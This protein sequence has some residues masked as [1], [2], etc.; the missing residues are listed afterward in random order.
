M[1]TDV[2]TLPLEGIIGFNGT[3]PNGLKV[4]SDRQHLVYPLGCNVVIEDITK[5][6][7][8]VP[9]ILSE[10]TDDVTCL[11]ISNLDG[12]YIASG[13]TTHMGFKATI[14]IWDYET[15][16]PIHKMALHKVKVEALAFTKNDRYLIS[17]GGQDDGSVVIWDVET[18]E[19]LCGSPAQHKSAG[20]TYCLN[21]SNVS[22]KIFVTGGDNTLRVWEIDSANRKIRP[23]DVNMGGVKRIIHCIQVVDEFSPAFIFC[24][25][26][27]GDILAIN[28]DSYRLT[29][30]VPEKEKFCQGITALAFVR[31]DNAIK[32]KEGN[33][34]TLPLYEFVIGAGDGTLGQYNIKVTIVGNKIKSSFSHKAC[35]K[36]WKDTLLLTKTSPLTSIALRGAGHQFFVGRANSQ[37][38]RFN[39]SELTCELKKTCHSKRINDMLFP[40]HSSDLLITCQHEEIRIWNLQKTK[41]IVRHRVANMTCNALELTEEGSTI[42]SA[43]GDGKIRAF[44]I[45]KT[46]THLYEKFVINDAHHKGVTAIACTRGGNRIISG[47]GEGQVRIWQIRRTM[48]TRGKPLYTSE[49][50]VNMKEHK[51]T[52]STIKMHPNDR[53]CASASTDGTCIIWDLERQVRNQVMFS[54][55][56]FY[57]LSYGGP[58]LCHIITSGTDRKISYWETLDGS[59]IRELDGAVTGAVLAMDMSPDG[60]FFVTGG[61]EK[62]VKV[63]KYNEGEVT[64][65]GGG[66]SSSIVKICICP[67]QRQIVSAG[68]DGAILIWR[69]PDMSGTGELSRVA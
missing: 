17:L 65:V 25:T 66:H 54:N 50:V 42:L 6:G 62:L 21:T 23:T 69:F 38:Y 61:E 56:L 57:C 10:H 37:L 51:G 60:Q 36:P 22:D 28:M 24:G 67:C 9:A 47:G 4:H 31:A 29:Y 68:S 32:K 64:H 44:G 45:D 63:W 13:Q 11:A 39:Y 27:T 53:E 26:T 48:D 30:V 35:V 7:N 19:A 20:N 41:E 8:G 49:L 58:N 5:E 3:V 52:V 46:Q 2:L 12:R 43:W 40:H 15:K 18:G 14:I 1:T 34:E 59:L 55:T 33:K 16:R